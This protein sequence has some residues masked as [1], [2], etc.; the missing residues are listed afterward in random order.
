MQGPD[1]TKSLIG[2]LIRFRKGLIPFTADIEAM[3]YQVSI[4]KKQWKYLR[5]F[6]WEDDDCTKEAVECKMKVHPFGAVSS[7]NCVT[8]A[9]HQTAFDNERLYG[10]E[11]A[12]TFLLDFYF[13]DWL[14]SLDD[15]KNA[16]YLINDTMKMC[17]EGGFNLTKVVCPNPKVI[18]SV[19]IEKRAASMKENQCHSQIAGQIT[20]V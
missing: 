13:D 15:E 18:N 1:L 11:A 14:K 8:I 16:V 10:K 4:P 19:P 5:F 7:K 9:L 6:W 17:A 12:E 2:V 3:Y 20:T